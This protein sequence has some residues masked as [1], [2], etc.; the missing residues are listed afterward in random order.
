MDRGLDLSFASTVVVKPLATNLTTSQPRGAVGYVSPREQWRHRTG[1]GGRA[2]A[3]ATYNTSF[4]GNEYAG[5]ALPGDGHDR[6]YDDIHIG[7]PWQ[8]MHG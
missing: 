3:N 2:S 8:D 5:E 4:L 1:V 7:L 6:V